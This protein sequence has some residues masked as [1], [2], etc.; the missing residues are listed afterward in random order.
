LQFSLANVALLTRDRS[1]RTQLKEE[2]D[3][4]IERDCSIRDYWVRTL[5]TRV[6]SPENPA[7]CHHPGAIH[8][9]KHDK[10]NVP[11]KEMPQIV[12]G[13]TRQH[14]R[15]RFM[16]SQPSSARFTPDS[17]VQTLAASST[18][19]PDLNFGGLGAGFPGSRF[20]GDPPDPNLSVGSNQV[21]E[22]INVELAIF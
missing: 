8:E 12:P 5:R 15:N 14:P 19:T 18:I 1:L 2:C 3:E 7:G 16:K 9:S 10:T 22:V 17:A 21:V 4:S 13:Q 20:L 6:G 11:L